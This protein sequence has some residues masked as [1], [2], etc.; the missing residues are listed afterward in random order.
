MSVAHPFER[1][2]HSYNVV[3]GLCFYQLIA[4]RSND[5]RGSL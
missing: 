1:T 4:V 5:S 2:G 3:K